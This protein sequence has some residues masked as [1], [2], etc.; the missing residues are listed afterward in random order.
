MGFTSGADGDLEIFDSDDKTDF[1]KNEAI[2]SLYFDLMARMNEVVQK[3][4]S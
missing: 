4:L 2:N 1:D 3:H